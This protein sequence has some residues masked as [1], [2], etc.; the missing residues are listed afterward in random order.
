[1]NKAQKSY[2]QLVQ[3]AW[4]QEMSGWDWQY[5][6]GR[7]Q[8]SPEPWKY[9]DLLRELMQQASSM[10]EIGTGGGELFGSLRKYPRLTVA[11]EAYPPSVSKAG[12]RLQPLGIRVVQTIDDIRLPLPFE[13]CA[14]DLAANRHAG[15]SA[16]EI[17]RVLKPGGR[18]ITQQVGGRNQFA[19]NQIL[20]EEPS[21]I[22][23]DWTLETARQEVLEAGFYLL[24]AE[25]AFPP[26][27]FYDIGAVVFFLKVISWQVPGFDPVLYEDKLRL[28]HQQI[29]REG[30][31]E[32]AA[33]RFIIEAQKAS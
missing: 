25:E 5:V 3:E 27:R 1:M 8:E 16:R 21:F 20:Q 7:M 33:H 22:Y 14:F 26:T 4:S 10:L 9:P 17:F 13:D 24:R 29:Q 18:F 23:S 15:Y 30:Y 31:L 32:T 2:S 12:R 28:I 11:T 19:F 6:S